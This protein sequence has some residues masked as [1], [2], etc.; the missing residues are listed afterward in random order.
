MNWSHCIPL[1]PVKSG[2]VFTSKGAGIT[3]IRITITFYLPFITSSRRFRH[4]ETTNEP[5]YCSANAQERER[6]E[7]N[8]NI[9]SEKKRPPGSSPEN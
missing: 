9:D 7:V 2:A 4:M 3:R 8:T 5:Y 6:K 1:W